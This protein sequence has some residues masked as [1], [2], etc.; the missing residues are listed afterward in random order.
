MAIIG[1]AGLLSIFVLVTALLG[2]FQVVVAH[3]PSRAMATDA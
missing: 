3:Q 1:P 2:G